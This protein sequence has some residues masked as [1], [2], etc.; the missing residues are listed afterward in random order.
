MFGNLT[1]LEPNLNRE[2]GNKSF[3]LKKELSKNSKFGITRE[4]IN[5]DTFDKDVISERQNKFA[6]AAVEIWRVDY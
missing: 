6:K 3:E 1:L 4:L 2:T 5:Y